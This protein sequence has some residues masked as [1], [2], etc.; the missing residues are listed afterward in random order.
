MASKTTITKTDKYHLYQEPY[1]TDR[2]YLEM[3][4]VEFKTVDNFYG[5]IHE[6]KLIVTIPKD[7][8]TE[9]IKG[10]LEKENV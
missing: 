10:S 4:N 1:D 3:K 7:V 9:L 2:M 6:K 8:W 5:E